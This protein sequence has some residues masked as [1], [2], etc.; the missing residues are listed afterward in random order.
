MGVLERTDETRPICQMRLL[1]LSGRMLAFVRSF[2]SFNNH[3]DDEIPLLWLASRWPLAGRR[4]VDRPG[5]ADSPSEVVVKIG[6]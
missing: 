2:V 1:E 6:H 4:P 3:D 5:S